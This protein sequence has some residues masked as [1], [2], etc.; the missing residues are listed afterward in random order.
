[1]E[2]LAQTV[3]ENLVKLRKGKKMT[4]SELADK[5]GYS[6]K[7]VSKWESGRGIPPLE[8]LKPMAD[9]F[10]VPI[11]YFVTSAEGKKDPNYLE[12]KSNSV[13]KL[14]I[15][16]L[17]VVVIW[18]AAIIFY[19]LVLFTSGIYFWMSFLWAIPAS[20]VILIIFNGIWGK[21]KWLFPILTVFL[22]SLLTCFCLQ[23]IDYN[24]WLLYLLG[25]PAQVAII[26][27]ANLKRRPVST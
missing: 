25:I 18:L 14:I 16:L 23:L 3:A 19:V 2:D 1:M 9:Y 8:V 24:I 27:W 20:S 13:N 10:G 11:D 26:L 21:R 7:A 22:W 17:A 12:T 4:Q 6:D 5:F 15:T